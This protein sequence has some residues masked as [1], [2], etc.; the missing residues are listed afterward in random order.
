MIA[1]ILSS[2]GWN[3][4]S[5]AD[6]LNQ[7]IRDYIESQPPLPL[8]SCFCSSTTCGQCGFL[9]RQTMLSRE[10]LSSSCS[11]NIPAEIEGISAASYDT[12]SSSD[13]ENFQIESESRRKF[14]N[15]AMIQKWIRELEANSSSKTGTA[16]P[17]H[18][19]D[20]DQINTY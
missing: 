17:V 8:D 5:E 11:S 2:L 15:I 16:V 18:E 6:G 10:S 14:E 1:T 3:K 19:V 13:D 4:N 7:V 20:Q 12:K 9:R